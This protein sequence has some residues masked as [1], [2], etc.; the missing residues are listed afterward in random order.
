MGL[1]GSELAK[2]V[3]RMGFWGFETKL[4]LFMRTVFLGS[5]RVNDLLTF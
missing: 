4:N 3:A 1:E 5:E 2:I